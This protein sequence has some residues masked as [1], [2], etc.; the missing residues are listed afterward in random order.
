MPLALRITIIAGLTAFCAG[1]A[2]LLLAR[3]P[4]LLIDL[5]AAAAQLLCL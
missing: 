2:W 3:G 1:A 4:A 5:S